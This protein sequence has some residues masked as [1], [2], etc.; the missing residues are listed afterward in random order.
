M[1]WALMIF[2]LVASVRPSRR[3]LANATTAGTIALLTE[4]FKLV[5]TPA[6][7]QFRRTLPGALL[8]GRAFSVSDLLAYAVG[9]LAGVAIL[10]KPSVLS[11]KQP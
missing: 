5:H 4:L 9:I 7:D 11:S 8:L 10:A 1:L 6:L 2:W 3:A